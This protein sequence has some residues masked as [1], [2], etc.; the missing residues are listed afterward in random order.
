MQ[1][2]PQCRPS[3]A[4]EAGRPEEAE[5]WL[6]SVAT[7]G[8]A[9]SALAA[10]YARMGKALDAQRCFEKLL[11]AGGKGFCWWVCLFSFAERDLKEGF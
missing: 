5:Q 7:D 1:R 4:M 2:A 9:L 3:L 11:A 6:E 10:G 8:V